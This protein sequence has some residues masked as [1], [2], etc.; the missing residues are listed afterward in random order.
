MNA[1]KRPTN[2]YP[3]IGVLAVLAILACLLASSC[4]GQSPPEQQQQ[5][6]V[7]QNYPI[8]NCVRG[9]LGQPPVY[10]ARP[11]YTLQMEKREIYIPTWRPAFVPTPQQQATP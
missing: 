6:Y 1:S 7:V 8:W 3:I 5:L 9:V 2:L 4:Y 10:S 11:L